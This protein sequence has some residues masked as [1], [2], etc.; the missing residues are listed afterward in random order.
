MAKENKKSGFAFAAKR[1]KEST[2]ENQ[3]AQPEVNEQ[4]IED[5][6]NRA[7][8]AIKKT[9]GDYGVMVNPEKPGRNRIDPKRRNNRAVNT[10]FSEEEYN[11]LKSLA[12]EAGLPISVYLRVMI[13]GPFLKSQRVE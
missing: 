4:E 1:V 5:G 2:G 11:M 13:I 6:T 7:I 9:K 10:Y 12:E 3:T 8:E